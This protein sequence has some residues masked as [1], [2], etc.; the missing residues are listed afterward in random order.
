MG[1]KVEMT[2]NPWR[3]V[4]LA[5]LFTMWIAFS[6]YIYDFLAEEGH[7]DWWVFA[8]PISFIWLLYVGIAYVLTRESYT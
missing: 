4:V 6:Y 8:V 1:I 2:R 3:Y 5:I 7:T